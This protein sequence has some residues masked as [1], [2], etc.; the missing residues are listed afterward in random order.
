MIGFGKYGMRQ[1]QAII[2]SLKDERL[3]KIDPQAEGFFDAILSFKTDDEN[4]NLFIKAVREVKEAQLKA[5]YKPIY[6][7]SEGS[8]E[9]PVIYQRGSRPAVGYSYNWWVEAVSKMPAVEGKNWEVAS[10]YQY[11]AFLVDIVNK[12]VSSGESLADALEEVV[13]DSTCCG[14][15]YNSEDSTEGK[16]FEPTGSRCV[17][18]FYD[19][20]NAYKILRCSN[21]EAGVFLVAGGSCIN[22]GDDNPLANLNRSTF[23][24]NDCFN[25]VAMLVL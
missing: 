17:C 3:V 1:K 21:S 18:G 16:D 15:Y 2:T 22:D 12:K 14:H 23:V 10:E 6:D 20:V 19:L 5:F 13:N 25:G 9:I 24:D 8:G 11:Y 7:P 4:I